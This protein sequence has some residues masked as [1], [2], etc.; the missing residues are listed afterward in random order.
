MHHDYY[1]DE[2]KESSYE[3]KYES[4]DKHVNEDEDYSSHHHN[5][6]HHHPY[7]YYE[8]YHIGFDFNF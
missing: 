8:D 3:H 5:H 7:S 4:I 1:D 2:E 6:N